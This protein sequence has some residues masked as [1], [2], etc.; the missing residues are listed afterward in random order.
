MHFLLPAP[1]LYKSSAFSISQSSFLVTWKS[2]RDEMSL[3]A[4]GGEMA[5]PCRTRFELHP[6]INQQR[7]MSWGRCGA[8]VSLAEHAFLWQRGGNHPHTN[9]NQEFLLSND[10]FTLPASKNGLN[11][12]TDF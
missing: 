6:P 10:D 2:L 12:E 9:I 11:L 4:M 8:V 5:L 1:Q 7:I 3:C